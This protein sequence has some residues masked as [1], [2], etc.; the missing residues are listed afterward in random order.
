MD[1]DGRGS[2][3]SRLSKWFSAKSPDKVSEKDIMLIVSE[4]EQS[5][6]LLPNQKKMIAN[7]LQFRNT[8]V[9][10]VMTHRVDIEAVEEQS[11]IEDVLGIAIKNGFSRIPVYKEDIDNIIG[12]VY[13]KDLLGLICEE[14]V[15]RRPVNKFIR[16][17]LYVPE[18]IKCCDLF[19]YFTDNHQH[20][21]VVVDE[22]G[23][24]SGIV[25]L[26]DVLETIVG[27]IQDEY[28]NEAVQITKV[29]NTTF[30]IDGAA[31]LKQV[32][33]ALGIP[34][35]DHPDYD[36]I[37]GFLVD[38]L[39]RIPDE[40]EHPALRYHEVEFTVLVVAERHIAKVRAVKLNRPAAAAETTPPAKN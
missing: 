32:S 9:E 38:R 35:E 16:E 27:Q 29:N 39:G 20:L 14:N 10:D 15:A 21:A 18:T 7:V 4:G 2:L 3:Q 28:D 11:K 12:A 23:G 8:T 30:T 34:I 17:V 33:E 25:T 31:D 24:T 26:E 36:T 6:V 13:V 19:R 40:G 5:G 22:Y 37:G 1:T